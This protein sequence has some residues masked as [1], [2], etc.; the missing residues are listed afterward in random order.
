MPPIYVLLTLSCYTRSFEMEEPNFVS[1]A[2]QRT[3][4]PFQGAGEHR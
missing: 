1:V 4:R 2:A 3:I